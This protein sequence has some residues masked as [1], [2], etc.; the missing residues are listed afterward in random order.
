MAPEPAGEQ[1]WP[2]WAR[3]ATE[4][5]RSARVHISAAHTEGDTERKNSLMKDTQEGA[6][7]RGDALSSLESG[8]VINVCNLWMF[9]LPC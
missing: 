4:R 8:F 1:R 5:P 7:K 2:E 3:S 6:I 9:V